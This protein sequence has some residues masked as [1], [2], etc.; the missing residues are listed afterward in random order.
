MSLHVHETGHASGPSVV[1]L[2]GLGVA[3]WMWR[4][5]IE[6]L[7]RD[8]HCLSI[9]LPGNGESHETE[10]VTLSQS[11]DAVA[12][13]IR[14]RILGDDGAHVVGL[15]LG[16]YVG[17]HLLARHPDLVRSLVVSGVTAR[18]FRPRWLWW[19]VTRI[20]AAAS[21]FDFVVRKSAQAMQLPDEVVPLYLRDARRLSS[22]TIRL[23]YDE[24]LSFRLPSELLQRQQPVLA[25]SGAREAR[26]VLASLDEFPKHLPNATC[27]IAPEAHHAWNAEHPELFT[28]MIRQWASSS[29]LSD[30]LIERG[31]R[32]GGKDDS[33]DAHSD[34][35]SEIF[36]GPRHPAKLQDDLPQRS[37]T[38]HESR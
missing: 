22:R 17:I 35:A 7:D 10:W 11:A 26:Q 38:V 19:S 28:S 33:S 5:Q 1:F 30:G 27:A 16:G 37:Q 13:V 4:D 23:V 29:E 21:S 24:V 32:Q 34:G 6:A 2:H 18:P 20:I 31:Q 8:F 3:G 15:S 12:Q 36:T 14:E 9:D 25:V